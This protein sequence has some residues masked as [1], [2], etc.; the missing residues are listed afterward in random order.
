LSN[1]RVERYNATP[2][3]KLRRNRKEEAGVVV[4]CLVGNYREDALARLNYVQRLVN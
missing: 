4:A 3:K 2:G 1:Q